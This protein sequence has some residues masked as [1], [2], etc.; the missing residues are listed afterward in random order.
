MT[1]RDVG[2]VLVFASPLLGALFGMCME[3]LFD[4]WDK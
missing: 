2:I 3:R 1:M 4:W